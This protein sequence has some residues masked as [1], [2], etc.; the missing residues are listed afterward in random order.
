VVCA[1]AG[2]CRGGCGGLRPQFPRSKGRVGWACGG[3]R[4]GCQTNAR[5]AAEVQ[6]SRNAKLQPLGRKEHRDLILVSPSLTD[7]FGPKFAATNYGFLYI[8]QGCRLDLRRSCGSLSKGADREL[9]HSVHS[10]CL[11][12][13]ADRTRSDHLAQEDAAPSLRRNLGSVFFTSTGSP[14]VAPS[15]VEP[16]PSWGQFP[17]GRGGAA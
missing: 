7:T 9:D 17:G 11:P 13:R 12:R 14:R 4:G 5:P 1:A 10:R 6:V 2:R 16:R 8:A 15:R 3:N